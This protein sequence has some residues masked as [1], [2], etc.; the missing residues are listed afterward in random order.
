MSRFRVIAI[1]IAR[2]IA[3]LAAAAWT[4]SST[5]GCGGAVGVDWNASGQPIVYGADDRRD[6]FQVSDPAARALMT[7]SVVALVSRRWAA[8]LPAG[9]ASAPTAG[10]THHLC[11]QEPFA[12]Q[13]AAAF[14][15]GVL[16]D[17]DLVL[18]AGHCARL[19]PV[20]DVGV[21]FDYLYAA[22]VT[23]GSGA[24]EI[25]G[26]AEIVDEAL[27]DPGAKPRLDF[28]WLRLTSPVD[29]S[30]RPARISAAAPVL[31]Q[32]EPVLS[33]A[34]DEGTPL[35][36]AAGGTVRDPRATTADY[37][38][39]D[40][41]TSHGA[42]GGGAFGKDL[43]LVGILARGLPDLM[44]RTDGCWTTTE[45]AEGDGGEQFTY[46]A[47]AL[48][49]LCAQKPNGRAICQA[50]GAGCATG[51]AR[52]VSGWAW[53]LCALLLARRG[54]PGGRPSVLEAGTRAA[55]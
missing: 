5:A 13:P 18:T 36:L 11:P 33:I 21:V 4:A 8:S 53:L 10:T 15:T 47:R 43:T 9:L 45:A 44:Q 25:A 52:P 16:V 48:Q 1:A 51:G 39:A 17:S 54:R 24:N 49:A 35:K 22:P 42:S 37:F 27:D 3:I 6:Y 30:R 23:L 14:C 31:N 55:G 26:I 29:P 34:A 12:D 38:V 20:D 19:V 41:D 7:E 50:E 2:W 32:G 46:A 28:A 40:T